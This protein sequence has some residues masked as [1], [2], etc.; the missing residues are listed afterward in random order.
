L[1]KSIFY[2][3]VIFS[4]L[5]MTIGGSV[6]VFV[7]VADLVSPPPY[8]QSYESYREMVLSGK[9]ANAETPP[10]EELIRQRYDRLVQEEQQQT[11]AR[12]V[13]RLIKSR[14]WIVIPL[15]VFIYF[16]RREKAQG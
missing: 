2:Y 1:I 9:D 3:L 4:T 10:S 8:Y 11:R 5:M 13:N 12:A 7:A 16:Q 14:G 15:P 6:S